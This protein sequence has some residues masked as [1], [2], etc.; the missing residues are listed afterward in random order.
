MHWWM[1]HSQVDIHRKTCNFLVKDPREFACTPA[2]K[3]T[4]FLHAAV[5]GEESKKSWEHSFVIPFTSQF[6]SVCLLNKQEMCS[7]LCSV[8]VLMVAV[9]DDVTMASNAT[10]KIAQCALQGL[11]SHLARHTSSSCGWSK[12]PRHTSSSC[13][14]SKTHKR[15]TSEANLLSAGSSVADAHQ[16]CKC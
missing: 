1:P 12:P 16:Q 9:T 15:H 6:Q 3:A 4:F 8:A 2:Q 5:S 10:T 7:R 14:W 11:C 13:E